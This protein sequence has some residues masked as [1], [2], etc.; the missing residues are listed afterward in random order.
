MSPLLLL[1]L[2][3][4]ADPMV[5]PNAS[6]W[7]TSAMKAAA[8]LKESTE[9]SPKNL[10]TV[11]EKTNW[12]ETGSYD[13][14]VALYKQLAAASPNAK[15]IDIG[16]TPAGRRMYL[17]IA[18]KDK[19]FTPEAARK[20][21]KPILLLQNGIHPG[22]NGGKDASV[23][24]LRDMLVTKKHAALLDQAI[25]LSIP[26][27]N[28]D[29]HEMV[30]PY[31]RINEQGPREM[32]FR[33]TGQ[34]YNL[35]RDYMKADAP[36]MRHWLRMWNQWQPDIM[37][38]NHVTDGSDLQHDITIAVEDSVSVHPA[39]A[40]WVKET[41]VPRMWQAMDEQGHV[42]GWYVGGP[43]R[44]G[45][46]F[47]REPSAP[48]YSTGYAAVRDRAAL[49]VETHSLKP[50]PVRAW[51]HYDVMVET[52]RVLASAGGA[53]R[54]A[55]AKADAARPTAI[56]IEFAPAQQGVPY[57]VRGL[58]T[59]TYPGV[60]SGAPVLR[61]L[62]KPRDIE[63]TLIRDAVVKTEV[64]LPQGYYIPRPWSVVAELLQAHGVKVETV[65]Q[66]VTGEFEV[67]RFS[68]VRFPAQPFEGRFMPSF[69]V[70][71]SQEKRTVPAGSFFVSTRQPL[72]KL[73]VNLLEP[74]AP[75][76]IVKWGLLNSIF[77]QKEYAAEYILEPLAQKMFAADPKLKAEFEAELQRDPAFAKNPRARMLWVY[78]RTPFYEADKDVYPIVRLR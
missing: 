75:D 71:A 31:N 2:T 35:N 74:Q 32:G 65:R 46:N 39:V 4:A 29:G 70:S 7:V 28:I 43:T 59:E 17:M 12:Q 47:V 50:F 66:P 10:L 67:T 5:A 68:G 61:Y 30:S 73:I 33:V 26:V 13:E 57:K 14:C 78:K 27:F 3:V 37:I 55:T 56:P 40:A 15:L 24:L 69:E 6:V 76:S 20:T 22:E 45:G 23:M 16:E 49:L 34:R 1:A 48:R 64:A 9:R 18:S 19:A 44:P 51:C 11:A 36:E 53:L 54:Q 38:D 52:L 8:S 25:V 60:V 58:E 21:G 62:A 41:W 72:A 42:M 63:M 77:E